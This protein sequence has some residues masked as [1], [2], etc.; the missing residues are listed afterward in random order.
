MHTRPPACHRALPLALVLLATG[1][2]S[3]TPALDDE[4]GTTTAPGES[5]SDDTSDDTSTDDTSTGDPPE[6]CAIAWQFRAPVVYGTDSLPSF[7]PLVL[8]DDALVVLHP[9]GTWPE[10]DNQVTRFSALDDPIVDTFGFSSS[11]QDYPQSLAG[12]PGGDLVIG[13]TDYVLNSGWVRRMSPSGEPGWV[14]FM[15]NDV[16]VLAIEPLPDQ[17]LATL[18]TRI[19]SNSDTDLLLTLLDSESGDTIDTWQYDTG[20]AG[21]SADLG[22][23]LASAPAGELFVAAVESTMPAVEARASVFGFAAGSITAPAWKTLLPDPPSGNGRP[24]DIELDPEGLLYVTHQELGGAQMSYL[25]A[26]DPTDGALLWTIDRTSFGLPELTTAYL[27]T[28][29]VDADTIVVA[30]SGSLPGN[31]HHIAF[32]V[33]LDH[34]GNPICQTTLDDFDDETGASLHHWSINAAELDASGDLFVSGMLFPLSR[35]DLPIE[36]LVAKLD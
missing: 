1:C 22:W 28:L 19:V 16:A 15:Q 32:V 31:V 34:E 13:Y 20:M 10:I 29:A 36:L 5:T 9:A 33:V 2:P 11:Q 18:E 4:G 23:A 35:P 12:L 24:T 7:T 26:L 30:G 27:A 21:E 25:S 17:R 6:P 3:D 14:D 8:D